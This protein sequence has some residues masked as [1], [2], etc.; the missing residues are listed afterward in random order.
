MGRCAWLALAL[1]IAG[2]GRPV[3]IATSDVMSQGCSATSGAAPI[4]AAAA[5]IAVL[6][7]LRLSRR[8]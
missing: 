5:L 6:L 3:A 7:A 2:C 4:G 8:S 1:M